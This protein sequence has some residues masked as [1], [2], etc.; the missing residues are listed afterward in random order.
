MKTG[1]QLHPEDRSFNILKEKLF[2]NELQNSEFFWFFFKQV[3]KNSG[4][5][6]NRCNECR[7]NRDCN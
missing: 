6:H 7:N 1:Y 4:Y 5:S 2:K 3:K